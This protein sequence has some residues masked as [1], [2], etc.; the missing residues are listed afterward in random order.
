MSTSFTGSIWDVGF[1]EDCGGQLKVKY[2]KIEEPVCVES[3]DDAH[4]ICKYLG[5]GNNTHF[6]AQGSKIKPSFSCDGEPMS[7]KHCVKDTECKNG[8]TTIYCESKCKH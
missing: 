5:C 6:Q 1:S 7:L 3:S 8:A 2:G 4:M